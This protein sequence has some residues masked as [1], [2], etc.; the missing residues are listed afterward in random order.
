MGAG[1]K[2]YIVGG[3]RTMLPDPYRVKQRSRVLPGQGILFTGMDGMGDSVYQRPFVR[4]IASKGATCVATSW[5]EI[6]ADLGVSYCR[7][8]HGMRLGTQSKNAARTSYQFV[9]PWP[10]SRIHLW[11]GNWMGRGY[12][13]LEDFEHQCPLSTKLVLDLPPGPTRGGAPFALVRL[14]S[15][16]CE[17]PTSSRNPLPK[18][19]DVACR[20]L[21]AR[22]IQVVLLADVMDGEEWLDHPH[23][24]EHDE[25]YIRGEMVIEDLMAAVRGAAVV[26]GGPSW[27]IPFSLAAQTP[28]VVIAGGWGSINCPEVTMDARLDTSRVRWVIPDN[29]CRCGTPMH[30]CD[31]TISG[32][33]ER[34][35]AAIDEVLR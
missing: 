13:I 27:I 26:L 20:Y 14:S 31:K 4:E 2:F 18:Y 28:L 33:L 22:G 7:D 21:R 6:Y 30:D 10:A 9:Q 29:F 12:T 11:Y 34:I 23:L 24:P 17:W 16:R 3:Q 5:P 35:P 8:P 15:V 1:S 19:I 25:A 32:Y